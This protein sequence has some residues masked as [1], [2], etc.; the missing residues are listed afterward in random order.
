[1]Y[2]SGE[3]AIILTLVG[4]FI[5]Y[6]AGRIH[7]DYL[8][9]EKTVKKGVPYFWRNFVEDTAVPNIRTR[10]SLEILRCLNKNIEREIEDGL[11]E[12]NIQSQLLGQYRNGTYENDQPAAKR[13]EAR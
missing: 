4:F 12:L 7:Q 5:A 8:L 11:E 6:A 1:M 10:E 3:A 2:I 13:R 9:R